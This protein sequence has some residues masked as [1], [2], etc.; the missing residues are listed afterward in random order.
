M[1]RGR[2]QGAD[3]HQP[4]E[5]RARLR[6]LPRREGQLPGRPRGSKGG[7]DRE[8]PTT[9]RPVPG[10]PRSPEAGDLQQSPV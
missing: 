9:S 10:M 1:N 8:P 6:P 5:S 4:A 2:A 7:A 3:R